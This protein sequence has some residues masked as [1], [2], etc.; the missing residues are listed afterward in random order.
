[1]VAF[2]DGKGYIIPRRHPRKQGGTLE[3][4]AAVAAG[5]GYRNTAAEK[6]AAF[7]PFQSGEQPKERGL[8]AA[9][10]P[11]ER[12]EFSLADREIHAP[13]RLGRR[14]G[15][16]E[17]QIFDF[18]AAHIRGYFPRRPPSWPSTRRNRDNVP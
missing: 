17:N 7:R 14:P 10:G 16:S 18:N 6:A 11:D 3:D 4:D 8:S 1:M 2:S 12:K 13:E 5:A 15:V 9:R